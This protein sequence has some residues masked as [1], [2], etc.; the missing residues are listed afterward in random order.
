MLNVYLTEPTG[1]IYEQ[2]KTTIMKIKNLILTSFLLLTGNML[3]SQSIEVPEN[4]QLKVAADYVPYEKNIIEAANW[5]K[6]TAFDEQVELRKKV[7]AFVVTSING[8]PTVNVELNSIIIDF[9]KKN[10]GN[11][12]LFMASSAKYVLEN[13]YSKDMRAKHRAALRDMISVYKSGKGIRKDK[14]MDKLIKADEEGKLDEWLEENL[15]INPR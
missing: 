11:L 13:S 6:A 9:N 3:Y 12:I 5:L 7:S 14:K 4:Y 8:S 1:S 15:K 10:E 2:T